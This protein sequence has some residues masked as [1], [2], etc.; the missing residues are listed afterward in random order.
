MVSTFLCGHMF[1]F[2]LNIDLGVELMGL[3]ITVCW[4]VWESARLLS[5]VAALFHMPTSDMGVP[6]F[7]TS[8]PALDA[9]PIFMIAILV[10]GKWHLIVFLT[11]AFLLTNASVIHSVGSDSLWPHGLYSPLGSSVHE[12]LQASR[13][14]WVAIPFPRETNVILASFHVLIGHMNIIF[15]EISLFKSFVHF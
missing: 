14:E 6:H 3:R 10:G 4:T 12:I 9:I 7:S 15:G 5:R 8:P 13:L 1:S 11:C 2:L